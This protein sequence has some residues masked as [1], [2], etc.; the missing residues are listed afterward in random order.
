META[1]FTTQPIGKLTQYKVVEPMQ[2]APF[3]LMLEIIRLF[4][5]ID[6]QDGD[7]VWIKFGVKEEIKEK[8]FIYKKIDFIQE[9]VNRCGINLAHGDEMYTLKNV[10]HKK[11][12]ANTDLYDTI[13]KMPKKR[14]DAL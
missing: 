11:P 10:L 5:I 6:V 1:S 2:M 13:F 4:K 3:I 7:L 9:F 8:Y 12:D 14:D